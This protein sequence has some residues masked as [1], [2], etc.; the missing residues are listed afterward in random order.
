MFIAEMDKR[1]IKYNLI[2]EWGAVISKDA[3]YIVELGGKNEKNYIA[4][5][6]FLQ[7]GEDGIFVRLKTDGKEIKMPNFEDLFDKI[8]FWNCF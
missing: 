2:T 1:K 3:E 8:E 6:E 5:R 7:T 4:P